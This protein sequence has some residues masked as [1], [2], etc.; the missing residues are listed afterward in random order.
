MNN[1]DLS[2]INNI[3]FI[4][5]GGIGISAVARMMLHNGKKVT[6]QDMQGGEIVDELKK[7]GIDIIIGQSY[8]NIPKDT[9]LIV[10]TIAIDTYDP[11]LARRVKEPSMGS[12]MMV[13]ALS[14]P[15]MLGE[16]TKDKY[17]IAVCG[18]HGKT[19]TTGM[20][21]EI[22]KGAS[23]NPSVIIGSLLA[24]KT[25]YIHGDS[26]IFVVEAC[27][28]RRSFLNINP[29]VLVITNIDE[30]HLDYYKDID[31]IKSAFYELV[32]KVPESGF[33]ICNPNDPNIKDV[34]KDSKAKIINWQ[35]FYNYELKLK[36]NSCFYFIR[37]CVVTR[38]VVSSKTKC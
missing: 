17:T 7:L 25:N 32:M 38:N 27:E 29:K 20:I 36:V 22:L 30:D 1:L 37:C 34:I 4:G 8:D 10:Y 33:I 28:Y 16:I 13:P 18:T 15:Q 26:D 3:H 23:K 9:E 19:T 12:E 24:G 21:A 6:G 31:D 2:K 14:Y 11:E 5:I 35:E